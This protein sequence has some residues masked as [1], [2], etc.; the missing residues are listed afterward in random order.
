M[1]RLTAAVG[2][3]AQ[4]FAGI[5]TVAVKTGI[6]RNRA[7]LIPVDIAEDLIKRAAKRAVERSD[8]IKSFKPLLP[9]E[10][11]IE[12]TR[13]DYCDHAD[14]NPALERLDARTARMISNSYQDFWF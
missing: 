11:K 3:A 4:F 6:S 8:R 12:Y 9:T 7:K 2:E 10:I 14:E 1:F 13:A 5:E